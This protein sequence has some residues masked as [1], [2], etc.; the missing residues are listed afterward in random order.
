MNDFLAYTLS[1]I[2]RKLHSSE[3]LDN[4]I[5]DGAGKGDMT[6]RFQAT[7][8]YL[9]DQ[10]E[11]CSIRF[12]GKNKRDTDL[13]FQKFITGPKKTKMTLE[14]F[15]DTVYRPTFMEGLAPTTCSNYNQ[16]LHDDI[17]PF[18]GKM[19][20]SDISVQNVQDFYNWMANGANNGRRK[21]LTKGSITRI[22]GLLGRILRVAKEMRLIDDSPVK[23]TLLKNNGEE[24]EHHVALS[25]KEVMRVKAMIPKIINIRERMYMGLLAYTGL[26][27]EEILGL[28]WEDIDLRERS[29]FVQRVVVYPDNKVAVVRNKTKTKKSERPFIIPDALYDILAPL[30]R[31]TGYVIF[32]K[33]AETPLSYSTMQRTYRGAF[34]FLG[35]T[36]Y[37]NHDW[38]ATYGTQLKEAGVTSAQVADLLGHA[39]TRMVETVYAPRRYEGVMKHKDTVNALNRQPQLREN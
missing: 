1:R 36:G 35:I 7:Y 16:Y 23:T 2:G 25:D 10:N 20:L 38:R 21:D 15:I 5:Q 12:E 8:T 29:G 14:E 3:N 19:A 17:L 13:K 33:D 9:D 4:E 24:S 39:D 34:D 26:R 6:K 22:G 28:R 31:K 37:D 32:G 27:K 30:E 18:L 11:L